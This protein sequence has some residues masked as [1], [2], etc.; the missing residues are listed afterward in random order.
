MAY[1]NIYIDQQDDEQ[2]VYIWDDAKGLVT[3]PLSDFNY[4]Y[5]KDP[6]GKYLSMTGERVSKTRRFTKGH[7]NVF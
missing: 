7:P 3:L 2:T 4:A 5:V 6:S 1:Q